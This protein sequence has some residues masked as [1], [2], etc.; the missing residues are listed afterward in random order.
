MNTQ[1]KAA[2]LD[3]L[4]ENESFLDAVVNAESKQDLQTVFANNGLEMDMDEIDA[5]VGMVRMHD[6]DELDEADL[7]NVAG[8]VGALTVFKWAIKGTK[9]IAKHAWNL[10]KKFANWEDS[11]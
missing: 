9:A 8:G 10:G 7:I 5:F 2:L 4:V 1:N 3:Q 6:S 11:L